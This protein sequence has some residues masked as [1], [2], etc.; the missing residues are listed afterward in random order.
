[1]G[2]SPW[3]TDSGVST[4]DVRAVVRPGTRRVT[5]QSWFLT[6]SSRSAGVSPSAEGMPG[7]PHCSRAWEEKES[8]PVSCSVFQRVKILELD[9]VSSNSLLWDF[10]KILKP[11]NLSLTSIG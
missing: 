2:L 9:C 4:S 6:L 8:S 5:D 10:D 7:W 1:M 3:D 11:L